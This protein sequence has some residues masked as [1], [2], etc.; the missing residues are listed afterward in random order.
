MKPQSQPRELNKTKVLTAN[1]FLFWG[2]LLW[3]SSLFYVEGQFC[4]GLVPV[5]WTSRQMDVLV[6]VIVALRPED[7][8]GLSDETMHVLR[9]IL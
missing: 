9:P 4:L 7:V 2:G 3:R 8:D 1:V 5:D 6:I